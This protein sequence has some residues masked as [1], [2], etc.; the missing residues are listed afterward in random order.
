MV[1][2]N[3]IILEAK[4]LLVYTNRSTIEI[5]AELGYNDSSHFSKFFKKHTGKSPTAFRKEKLTR[6]G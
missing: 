6:T 5:A 1:I 4:R 3:R 2:N